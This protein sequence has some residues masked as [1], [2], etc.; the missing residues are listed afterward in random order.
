MERQLQQITPASSDLDFLNDLMTPA[1]A[2]EPMTLFDLIGV[3]KPL[4]F[5]TL[6]NSAKRV[7]SYRSYDLSI[8]DARDIINGY[9]GCGRVYAGVMDF[10]GAV[11]GAGC[12]YGQIS[13][14]GEFRGRV[15]AFDLSGD[16]FD[17]TNYDAA[18]GEG[19][20]KRIYYTVLAAIEGGYTPVAISAGS[21]DEDN[22][23]KFGW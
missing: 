5:L 1:V 2:D 13:E 12:G 7:D 19:A 14:N 11:N 3:D 18:N 8:D 22:G 23:D 16:T 4:M 6:Y 15:L 10:T 21:D 20:G 9:E 17:S